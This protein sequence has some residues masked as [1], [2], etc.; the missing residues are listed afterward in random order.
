MN[1]KVVLYLSDTVLATISYRRSIIGRYQDQLK[2]IKQTSATYINSR[3]LFQCYKF[4][5]L[6]FDYD[7]ARVG[8]GRVAGQNVDL[9]S[10]VHAVSRTRLG[11][12]DCVVSLILTDNL[13]RLH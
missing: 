1:I 8:S 12:F 9:V 10:T 6:H 2:A 4:Y 7:Y 11:L 5:N 13:L 3:T